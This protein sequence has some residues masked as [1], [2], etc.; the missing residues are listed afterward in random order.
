VLEA[1][2][3]DGEAEQLYLLL[4]E[5][6]ALRPTDLATLSGLPGSKVRAV[7]ERLAALGLVTQTA[8]RPT[9]VLPTPPGGA[10]E[11][12]ALQRQ[13]DITTAR[14][15]AQQLQRSYGSRHQHA[16]EVVEIVHSREQIQQRYFQLQQ[17]A[18]TEILNFDAPPYSVSPEDTELEL[19]R[20]AAGISYRVIYD[21]EALEQPGRLAA[22]DRLTA[23]GQQARCLS[24][25]PIKLVVADRRT[26]LLPIQG[27]QSQ[28]LSGAIVVHQSSLLDMLIL[29]FEEHWRRAVSF[30]AS[31]AEVA[32]GGDEEPTQEERRI[33]ALLAAGQKDETVARQLGVTVRTVRR[34][35]HSLCASLDCDSRFQLALRTKDRGWL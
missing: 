11:T 14:Q 27:E 16:A 7:V 18:T 26:A 1:L 20:L 32:A 12:L 34:H 2:G 22:V 31:A 23:A 33:L 3:V 9:R 28:A 30:G 5:R 15:A 24:R 25:V 4:L 21:G 19:A 8:S 35:I 10:L 17:S 13:R 29:I 6:G